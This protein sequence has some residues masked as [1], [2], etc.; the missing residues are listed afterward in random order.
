MAGQGFPL[1]FYAM[2]D[3]AALAPSKTGRQS[4]VRAQRELR[5]AREART[6]IWRV[7]I[8]AA[9]FAVVLGSNLFVGVVMMVKAFRH[10]EATTAVPMARVTYPLLDGV[11][12]RH[13]LFDNNTVQANKT[14]FPV[15]TIAT[16][17]NPNAARG[18]RS[19][20]AD[21]DDLIGSARYSRFRRATGAASCHSG[22]AVNGSA[23]SAAR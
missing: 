4:S 3:I 1:K 11:F 2:N 10:E 14:R 16:T 8:V 21:A 9:F 19:T 23:R 5:R 6:K 20:G 17:S 22:A 12:C 15:A 7:S 13:I 18:R